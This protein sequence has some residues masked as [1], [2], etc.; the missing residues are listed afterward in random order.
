[1]AGTRNHYYAGDHQITGTVKEKGVPDDRPVARRVLLFDERTH[2]VVGETWS[3]P[4]T[5]AYRFE[6]ISPVP[7]YV[8][9]AY[10]Y[11]HNF[12]AVIADNLRAEPMQVPA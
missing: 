1:M 11:K 2:V 3:D 9:V 12:R 8:V 7:R 5:G 6:K 10:D 4:G